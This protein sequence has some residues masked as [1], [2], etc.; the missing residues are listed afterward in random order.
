M[1]CA[2]AGRWLMGWRRSLTRGILLAAVFLPSPAF[3]ADIEYG[4]HL[5]S[6]CMTC[7]GP[8]S[9]AATTIPDINGMAETTFIE[10]VK[11]YRDKSLPNV[12]MQNIAS[13]LGD[14]EIAALAAFFA[15]A[16][17]RK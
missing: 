5:S 6:E 17:K 3:S 14:E 16:K 11:A 15:T 2:L 13:R 9:G 10:V 4:R 7:H 8:A 12:V 1:R